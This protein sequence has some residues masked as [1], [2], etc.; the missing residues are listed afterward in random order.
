MGVLK[1]FLFVG[2]LLLHMTQRV[3][4]LDARYAAQR[5]L[6]WGGSPLGRNKEVDKFMFHD[7]GG[8]AKSQAGLWNNSTL[9][10]EFM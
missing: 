6:R 1:I 9:L 2:Q 5:T 8:L 7:P 4:A 3:A 10:P